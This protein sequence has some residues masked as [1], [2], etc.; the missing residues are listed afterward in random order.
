MTSRG[1]R[2]TYG[3]GSFVLDAITIVFLVG[4][5]LLIASELVHLSLVPVFFGTSALITAGL[6]ALGILDTWS[7]SLLAWALTS[8]A[9]T[10]PLR[11]LAR[12]LLPGAKAVFDPSDEDKDAMGAIVEVVEAVDDETT[13]GRIRHQGTTWSAR[14]VEGLIPRGARAKLVYRDKLSWVIE[15]LPATD[16]VEPAPALPPADASARVPV[17]AASSNDSKKD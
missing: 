15:A 11:P 3:P 8:V 10:V 2:A 14:A 7:G 13:Q 9:L 5:L 4:G 6:H 17:G 16:G 1:P 12:R